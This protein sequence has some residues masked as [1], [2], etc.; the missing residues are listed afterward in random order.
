MAQLAYK[1]GL[2]GRLEVHMRMR[3]SGALGVTQV[4]SL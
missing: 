1:C 3:G 2:L 4:P